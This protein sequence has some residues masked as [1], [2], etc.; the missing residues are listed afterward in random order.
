[1]MWTVIVSSLVT[2]WIANRF[3]LPKHRRFRM[4]VR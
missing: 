1:M 3:G 2:V 4:V